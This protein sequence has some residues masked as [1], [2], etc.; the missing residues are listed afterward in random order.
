MAKIICTRTEYDKLST[1]LEDNPQ[2]LADM[3]ITYD[4]VE[5][6]SAGLEYQVKDADVYRLISVKSAYQP[7]YQSNQYQR[8]S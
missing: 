3:H 5:K 4:V 1:V 6:A 2:F 8:V 7:A